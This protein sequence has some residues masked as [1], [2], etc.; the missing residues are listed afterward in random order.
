MSNARQDEQTVFAAADARKILF[1][2]PNVDNASVLQDGLHPDFEAVRLPEQ[3][4][5]I[6]AIALHM[7]GRRDVSA[8]HILSH[9]A[10]GELALSGQRVDAAALA[11]RPALTAAIR[12]A[13]A[14]DSEIVLYGCS[15]AQGRQG[16]AFVG[17]LAALLDRP[18]A[19]SAHPVGA[20]R[21]GGG[22]DIPARGALA[23]D[24]AARAAYPATLAKAT[25]GI[26]T[27]IN[28]VSTLTANESGVTIDVTKSDGT[29][30]AGVSSG[31]LDAGVIANTVTY[32]LTFG[33]AVNVTQ[34]QIA[35][36]TNLSASSNYVFT[37][38]TGTA[39]TIA[40][41]SGALA[42][43]VATLSPGDWTGITSFTVSYAG[44]ASWRVGLD[45]I[46]FTS[47]SVSATSNAAGFNTTNGTNLTPASTFAGTN[48]TLTI[49]SSTHIAG[50][51]ADG[52]AGTD[53][54]IAPDGSDFANFTL[55]QNFETLTL[56][57]D[58]TVTMSESQHDGFTTINGNTGTEVITLSSAN[59]DGNVTGAA[60]IE[61]YNLNGAFTFTLGAAGQNVTGNAGAN[62]TVQS[63][64]SIDTLTGTL[65][66]GA[67]G[68]DTLVLDTGDNIAGATVSNF[69]NLTLESGGSFTMTVA[70]HDA[71]T[72]TVTAAG[73]E[74]ITFSA[75]GGD[76]VT[77]GN[78][79]VETYVLG[80]GGISFTLGA[81]AQNL[82]GS[83]GADTVDVGTRTATG[84]LNGN[85]DTDTL[86]IG[87]GGSIAGATVTNF[88]NLTLASDASVTIAAS[89]LSQFA[90]TITAAGTETV[91]VTGDGSFT[92]L[93]N[94][95]TFSVG[96][97]STNARTIT[98][99]GAGTSVSATSATDAITFSVGNVTYTGTLTGEATT[100]D[101][102]SLADGANI[103]G[104][105][106]TAIGTL[107]VASGATVTMTEAQ[108]DA[109]TTITGT[110]TNK[111]VITTATNGLTGDADIEQYQLSSANSF[112]LGAAGQTITGSAGDDTINVSTLTATGTISGGAGTDTLVMGNGS[113]IA[114]AT[115]S[116][117]EN[118]SLASGAS[119]TMTAAQH[120]QFSGTITA[121]GTET[122]NVTGD[123]AF[124]T[125]ANVETYS[126]GDD[127]TN[128]RTIT[129]GAAGTSV[130]ATSGTDAVTFDLGTLTYTGTI[131][132]E[133]TVNDTLS[134][135]NGASIAGGTITAV[136]NL[137]LASGAS[138]TM[139]LSQLAGFTGT[140]TAAGTETVTLSGDGNFSTVANIESY[141]LGDSSTDART[142]TITNAGHSA[143]ATSATDAVT[144][145]TGTLTLTGTITGEGTVN[146]TLSIGNTANISGATISGIENLTLATGGS[147]TMTAAQ[148]NG[149][150]GTVTAA[151]TETVTLSAT[152]SIA[153]ASLTAIE[154]I[155]TSAD[156]G[157]QTITLTAAQATGKTLTAGDTGQDHFV[158][159]GSAGSQAITGS[160]GADT[161]DGGADADTVIGGDGADVLSGADGADVISGGAGFDTLVGGAG[162]DTFTGSTGDFNGDT[163]SDFA[164]GDSIVVVGA[165]KSS[166]NGTAASASIDI[167][168]STATTLT[169]VSSASGT[170]SAVFAGGNTTITLVA[171]VVNNG[172]GGGGGDSGSSNSGS[173]STIVVTPTTPTVS[174][175]T[176]SQTISN[177]GSTSGSAT[178][179]ENSGNNSNVV[180]ATLPGSVSISAEGPAAA[181]SGQTAT[182]TL[183]NAVIARGSTSQ[184][185]LVSGAQTFLNR[186]AS[187]STLDIRTLVPTTTSTVLSEP[188]IISGTSSSG[189]SEAFVIDMR[190]L[191]SGS[192]LQ[193][194]NIEFASIIGNATVNGGS[195]DN[196][197]TGDDASQFISLGVGDDTLYGGSGAD[198]IGSG[199][200]LDDLYGEDGDDMV[201][202]G[203]DADNVFGGADQDMV[204]GNQGADVLYGNQGLDTLYGG[205]D[206]D[207]LYGGQHEDVLYGNLGND[208][209]FGNLGSDT[210][211]GGQGDDVLYG[212]QNIDNH[213]IADAIEVLYGNLGNDTIY[214]G[215]GDDLMV[216]GDG[217]DLVVVQAGGGADTVSDFDGASG[218]RI[219]IEANANGTSIDTFAELQAA[220]TTNASGYVEIALGGGN[221]LT[222]N[223]VTASNLQSDWFLFG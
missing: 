198:T 22:W 131:T 171:P 211:Y 62:Q 26:V 35:E 219:Q 68:S 40:D 64:S 94:V 6:A 179:V 80:T 76:T 107:D 84:T 113:S 185:S 223:G 170:F 59:G 206:N 98:V 31:F 175:N 161:I 128:A 36:F 93:A 216:G 72:G 191:P 70:Q 137:T 147:F 217:Q 202:G 21:L 183:V 156:A 190:S 17:A 169:G 55:L 9:G 150:T 101:T 143:T 163:I 157:A 195:G 66:G 16:A 220:A 89:Q 162:N 117:F 126:V 44:A 178:I 203:T 192:T 209:L 132:G 85:G 42:G 38:N 207:V 152:G 73:T 30:M 160:A 67:G 27:T 159:T 142:I 86:S 173:T 18:V 37:P 193:L 60:G 194:D 145:D 146:D 4:D 45:N 63:S 51:T 52:G 215:A 184:S 29:P 96:D 105:T 141:V 188:I 41:D 122:V 124:T 176:S 174:T 103:A 56:A 164:V 166:L 2:D 15:V 201:F 79:A 46:V 153:S 210:I 78:S 196:Y 97:D 136:E 172:G 3:G 148:L 205:Q 99:S 204:Y 82:T 213:L 144:F 28:T 33:T 10:P 90:G 34:F 23:F 7:A 88:E 50:S 181:Q 24:P 58:A 53:T 11:A 19:A 127:S 47:A 71:F 69:E 155:A 186:L 154:T 140:V 74:Q 133:G 13:L 12:D 120:A 199:S 129:V 114:G 158:V 32:T 115:V 75:T 8:L 182:D 222:L 149:F 91:N 125:L 116:T 138:V 112:T 49:A 54:I 81:A 48:D 139:T 106:I 111:I 168:G 123:G 189:Q 130:S 108:H 121:A 43:S 95:E 208:T 102:L 221:T 214:G 20:Q 1:I 177:T 118:L 212:G 87:N 25:F 180:T 197:V 187:T 167:S 104:G 165:D 92:T 110:G 218:D 151:G 57:A 109:F 100:G 14:A 39:V 61:T 119:V 77:T 134:L 83:S 65:N 5:P 200:G 135:G